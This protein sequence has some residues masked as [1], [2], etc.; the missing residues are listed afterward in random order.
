MSGRGY[1]EGHSVQRHV[2]RQPTARTKVFLGEI[3]AQTDREQNPF[4]GDLID[5]PGFTGS[6]GLDNR[7]DSGIR[8]PRYW[9]CVDMVHGLEQEFV[10]SAK[11]F[12][13]PS[14]DCG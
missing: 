5:G 11:I 1:A 8:K 12:Q 14:T 9:Q 3:L 13:V 10:C 7:D 2:C 4:G 6:G